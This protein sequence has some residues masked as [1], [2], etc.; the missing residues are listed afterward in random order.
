MSSVIIQQMVKAARAGG[1]VLL[2]H[3]HRLDTLNIVEKTRMDYASEVDALA[4]DAVITEL[5]QAYP[6]DAI[7]G[8]EGGAQAG[9][10]G[11]NRRTWVID[12]LDGTSNYLRGFPHW[13]VSIA[14]CEDGDP[15]HAVIFDPIHDELF[16]ASHGNGAYLNGHRIGVSTH[17]KLAGSV[18]ATGFTP[19]ERA[20]ADA[21]LDCLKSLLRDAEDLRQGGSS[22]LDLAWVACGRLDGHF[23]AGVRPWDVA[24][25]VLLVREAGGTVCDFH[26]AAIRS[27]HLPGPTDGF[28]LISGSTPI[29]DALQVLIVDSGY[30]QAFAKDSHF[31]HRQ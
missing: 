8:E 19:R 6:D 1:Q 25:G 22:A 20:R 7:L 13:C 11:D 31:T 15:V 14:L 21:Q 5:R 9:A 29:A 30:A 4:E 2:H 23:E 3:M 26:G 16:T 28:A 24:A 18:I 12:P 27:L 10:Q 17:R